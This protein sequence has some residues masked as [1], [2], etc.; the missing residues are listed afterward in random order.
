[1]TSQTPIK[2]TAANL[3]IID[4]AGCH[5]TITI[6]EKESTSNIAVIRENGPGMKPEPFSNEE[7][8]I[9]NC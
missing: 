8:E 7:E 2:T 9:L 6:L 5:E 4:P 1:M 3:V